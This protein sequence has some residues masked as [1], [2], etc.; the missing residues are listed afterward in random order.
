MLCSDDNDYCTKVQIFYINTILCCNGYFRSYNN[1]IV[2]SPVHHIAK[3][4][5]QPVLRI[6]TSIYEEK[7]IYLSNVLIPIPNVD[8]G[9]GDPRNILAVVINKDELG[10]KLGTKSGTLRGLYTRNQ[11]ELSDS[12]FLD[13]GSINNENELSLRPA[14]RIV[15]LCDGHSTLR[16]SPFPRSTFGIGIKTLVPISTSDS[17][18]SDRFLILLLT[19]SLTQKHSFSPMLYFSHLNKDCKLHFQVC[20]LLNKAH[21]HFIKCLKYKYIQINQQRIIFD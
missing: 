11:F 7:W 5:W 13:I 20:M 17:I 18:L 12:K 10:Y 15:S 4:Y 6:L 1:H 8:R 19:F 2:W 14:V 21:G 16:G 3:H 9:K